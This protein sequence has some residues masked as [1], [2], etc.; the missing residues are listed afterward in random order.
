MKIA[1]F[2]E[3]I[4]A[5]VDI[6]Y[7]LNEL[8][9]ENNITFYS[10]TIECPKFFNNK[11]IKK[12][13]SN[14][15]KYKFLNKFTNVV[16]KV[17]GR[18]PKETIQNSLVWEKY[19][20]DNSNNSFFIY[21]LKYLLIF[22]SKF[23]SKYQSYDSYLNLLSFKPSIN[24]LNH[25]AYI[26]FSDIV[27]NEVLS[28]LLNKNKK[29]L[30]YVYSWDHPPK[31][32]SFSKRINKFLTWNH[33]ISEDL[34][35]LHNIDSHKIASIGS[36]QFSFLQEYIFDSKDSKIKKEYDVLF[37]FSTGSVK[38]INQ[39]IKLLIKLCNA[40][41]SLNIY[42][43]LYPFVKDKKIYDPLKK[44]QN[45]NLLN[46]DYKSLNSINDFKKN[47]YEKY[48]QIEKSNMV[49]HCG[50]TMGL[51]ACFLNTNIYFISLDINYIDKDIVAFMHQYQNDKYLNLNYDNVI[52]NIKNFDLSSLPKDN[53]EYYK[54]EVTKNFNLSTIYEISKKIRTSI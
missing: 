20:L 53:S 21:H 37:C 1:I 24:I 13:Y 6:S 50:T 3:H 18:H 44:I 47:V 36:S 14:N 23:F 15:S 32:K 25:D 4:N 27:D 17:F 52:R 38:L 35:K 45:L 28:Y 8:S 9:K 34:V 41:T 19:A 48:Y 39:E 7:L 51:E 5:R 29:V 33:S 31:F 40:N 26:F 12:K 2:A 16:F 42:A 11:I 10:K 43:R 30:V 49:I 54:N 46:I 22:L